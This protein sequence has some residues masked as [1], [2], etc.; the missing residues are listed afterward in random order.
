MYINLNYLKLFFLSFGTILFSACSSDILSPDST[1]QEEVI[2]EDIIVDNIV[3]VKFSPEFGE[4]FTELKNSIGTK[5][6]NN[7]SVDDILTQTGGKAMFRLF[8]YDEEYDALMRECGLHLWYVIEFDENSPKTKAISDLSSIKGIEHV[9]KVKRPVLQ[10]G[11][12]SPVLGPLGFNTKASNGSYTKNADNRRSSFNDPEL[13]KQWNYNNDGRLDN[14]K[15]GA[16]I[17]L[18]EAWKETTGDPR[19]IVAVIDGGIETTHKD[20][21][22]NLYT[23]KEEYN[24]KY[25]DYGKHGYNFCLKNNGEEKVEIT[26]H[27]H[28]THVA[29]TVAARNN[30][31]EGVCGIAGGDDSKGKNNGVRLLSCQIMDNESASPFSERA[32]VYAQKRGAVIAQC[33][34]GW[35]SAQNYNDAY[36]NSDEGRDLSLRAAIDYFIKYAGC[37]STGKQKENSPMKGGLVV[38][39]AGNEH[40]EFDSYPALYKP[41]IAVSAL[42][43]N[44]KCSEFTTYGSWVDISA[45]GGLNNSGG[46]SNPQNILSTYLEGTYAFLPGTSMA[47]PHVS[48]IAALVVSKYGKLGYTADE[49]KEQVLT[50]IR[51]YDIYKYND[52]YLK[53][54]LGVGCIDAAR[55]LKTNQN[56]NPETVGTITANPKYKEIE[57][58]WD[59]VKDEDDGTADFYEIYY[60]KDPLTKENYNKAKSINILAY[61]YI[62]ND[63]VTF[64]LPELEFKTKYY[65]AIVAKDRWGLK[66]KD[67]SISSSSTLEN[68]PP[69][70]SLQSNEPIRITQDETATNKV[71]VTEPDNQSWTF[72]IENKPKGV[73]AT[74]EDDGI[75]LVFSNRD[76]YGTHKFTVIVKDIYGFAESIEV[77][78][79]TYENNPPKL[80]K[81]FG[82]IFIP[83]NAASYTI[84][85]NEYIKE[86]DG[87]DISFEVLL[88][89]YNSC[90]TSLSKNILSIVPVAKGSAIMNIVATDKYGARLRK[91]VQIQV[92]ED[93]LVYIAY[94]VPVYNEFNVRLNDRVNNATIY[95]RNVNGAA[96]LK[97]DINITSPEDRVVKL[98]LS[99]FVGGT[100]VLHVTSNGESYTEQFIKL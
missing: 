37:D 90:V 36:F 86:I 17:N 46:Y 83:T 3:K 47:C 52:S 12:E 13:P 50:A 32:F 38:F 4:N 22:D 77:E 43:S 31:N 96:M 10:K 23:I 88:N 24:D 39:A 62:N 35:D 58:S 64:E 20:L 69:K 29:G 28:G 53:G 66:S 67:V 55:A 87:H 89:N 61:E 59:A 97:Q 45:P 99:K 72:E 11:L 68:F 41:V 21:K 15:L 94:P 34:W 9:E 48:G 7:K 73:T 74:Q 26:A 81:E 16:D 84:D 98:D 63:I 95:I 57:L 92:A 93:K 71:I 6:S 30:N 60:S 79:E 65:Y 85:L 40:F 27:H 54:K 25:N 49:L 14:S 91:S 5:S 76:S 1:K 82:T 100:Y 42:S 18:F 51:P 80:I 75:S 33:S 44:L 2:K 56:K 70:L 78:F 8:P 19:V